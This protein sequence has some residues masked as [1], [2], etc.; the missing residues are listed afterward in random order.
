V[1]R[2]EIFGTDTSEVTGHEGSSEATDEK[3]V[4][5]KDLKMDICASFA[6]V[7]TAPY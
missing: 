6:C 5:Q 2:P 4:R 7:Y 1:A 3:T